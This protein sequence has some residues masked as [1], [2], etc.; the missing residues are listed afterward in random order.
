LEQIQLIARVLKGDV[1]AER[2]LY[3]THVDRVYRLAYRMTGDETMAE[4][5]TQETFIKVFNRLDTFE[6]RSA[7]ST[8]IHSVTVSV[9][10]SGLRKV[11]R[12]RNREAELDEFTSSAGAVAGADTELKIRLHQAIDALPDDMRM[13]VIMH[14]IEGYKHE[15]I[16]EIFGIPTGTAKSRLSRAHKALRDDLAGGKRRPA[17]EDWR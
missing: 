8:W 3:E 11:K 6:G 1:S 16:A 10:L 14:D 5:Y 12:L 17:E 15:E 13:A 9:V 7:L 4:D 2:Q